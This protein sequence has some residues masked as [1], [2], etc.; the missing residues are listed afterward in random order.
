VHKQN[1]GVIPRGWYAD[2]LKKCRD[3]RRK[4]IFY[5][6][7]QRHWYEVLGFTIDADCV[8]CPECRRADQ[9]L[10]RRFQRYSN[11]IARTDLTDDE[12]ATLVGDA[13]FVWDNGLLKKRDKLKRI[14]NQARRRI[15]NHPATREID[16]LIAQSEVT[17]AS[18]TAY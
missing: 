7:E 8:R 17:D 4:F 11:A 14:R 10:R 13:A 9:T 18:A 2:I 3:C 16:L 12:F 1:F 15:P 5:A 6:E